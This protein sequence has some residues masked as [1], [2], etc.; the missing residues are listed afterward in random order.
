MN[1]RTRG[2]SLIE[3]LI[4]LLIVLAA[5][6]MTFQLFRENERVIRDQNL[7][8][9]MQQTA[10]VVISQIADEIRMAGQSVPVFATT[11][12][13]S[14]SEATAV[15]LGT[16]A[17]DRIDFRAGLSNV[18]TVVTTASPI[19]VSIG[20]FR[21]LGIQDSSG[22]T[23]GKFVYIWGPSTASWAWVRAQLTSVTSTTITFIAQQ[24]G[25]TATTVH[26]TAA[27]TVSLEEAISIY[28]TAGSVRRATASDFTNSANPTWNPSNEI[29]RNVRT[30]SFEYYDAGGNPVVPTLLSNRLS[31]ARV[32]IHLTVQATAALANGQI[33]SYSLALRTIPRNVRIRS[34]D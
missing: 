8:M 21:T 17:S 1:T 10:R 12:D 5:G 14:P 19:D 28:L 2:F 32:D 11:Y 20:G 16:S 33:A 13:A 6:M 18:E 9:E 34:A 25:G 30:L 3:L 26:F 15:F 23:V 7:I 27:P 22:L 24:A 29:G 4:A 31:I